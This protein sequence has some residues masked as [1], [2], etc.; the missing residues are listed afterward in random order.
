[1]N[2][3]LI[4]QL[5]SFVGKE[6]IITEQSLMSD[7]SHDETSASQYGSYP[8]IVVFPQTTEHISS[9]LKLANEQLI[10][11]T[12]RGGGTG[13]SGGAIPV[14]GGIL[15][16]LERM[17][18][19]IEIDSAN[20]TVTVEAGVITNDI[21]V[22]V[23]DEGLYFAGYPM[24]LQSC[25]IGGNV[26]ENAGG[27]KAIK[28]GVTGRY[29]LGLEVVLPDGEIINIGG[30]RVKDVAGYDLKS[31]FIG[32]EG[33][34]GIISKV[35][36]KLLPLPKSQAVLLALYDDVETAISSVPKIM[37]NTGII[38]TGLEYMDKLSVRYACDFLDERLPVKEAEAMLLIEIDGNDEELLEDEYLKIGEICEDNGAFEVFA[39]DNAATRER[40]WKIRR[41]IPE[42]LHT[43]SPEQSSEDIVVPIASIPKMIPFL[44]EIADKYGIE[45]PCF[46]HAGDGNLHATLLKKTEQSLEEWLDIQTKALTDIYH[47]VKQLGGS[48]TGEHGIG[49][50]RKKYLTE[51]ITGTELNLMKQIKKA[52][53]PNN[54]MNP[55]KIFDL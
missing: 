25:F 51:Q 2:K 39:A 7:Y 18:R 54:I 5:A 17:N 34:L 31:L 52:F 32:S 50:K 1:M 4:E 53:D 8:E 55:G 45:I 44:K 47:L 48:I 3:E 6:N 20:M 38:P 29:V 28:Y 16:S 21:N 9:I 33:T 14:R 40:I 22:A 36:L 11:V 35:I 23:A 27:G 43:L 19:I 46:G 15:L 49:L 10:P 37:I 41:S 26:A 13:L 30:K 12:P 24:S 42:A